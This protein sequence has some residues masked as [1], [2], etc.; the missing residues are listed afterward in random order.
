MMSKKDEELRRYWI[1]KKP[2]VRDAT[3]E[4]IEG[5]WAESGKTQTE[6]ASKHGVS[7]AAIRTNYKKL[8]EMGL[9]K[10]PERN[11][12]CLKCGKNLLGVYPK[13]RVTLL[14]E[15]IKSII[16]YICFDC[17]TNSFV[18]IIPE[19]RKLTRRYFGVVE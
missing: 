19:E 1:G 4:Y 18:K 5:I 10:K 11:Y 2:S 17:Y 14:D 13:Y 15:G 8:V 12:P 7:K 3:M 9:C 16:G 6:L